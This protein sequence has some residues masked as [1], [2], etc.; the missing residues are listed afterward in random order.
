[1]M[2]KQANYLIIVFAFFWGLIS[3]A[4]NKY[5]SSPPPWAKPYSFDANIHIDQNTVTEGFYYVLF[6]Q[7][8]DI[9]TNS[10]YTHYAIKILNSKSLESL[11]KLQFSFNPSFQKLKIHS[12]KLIR[13]GKSIDKSKDA[14]YIE[15]QNEEEITNSFYIGIKNINVILTDVRIDDIVEFEYTISGANAIFENKFFT[16]FYLNNYF[17]IKHLYYRVI[18]PKNR[19]IYIHINS[20]H[21]NPQRTEIGENEELIWER[22][23]TFGAISEQ[24]LPEWHTALTKVELSEYN[25]WEQVARWGDKLFKFTDIKSDSL[26]RIIVTLEKETTEEKKI[27][28]ALRY[29]QEEIRY[30]GI[31]LGSNSHLPKNLNKII[32]DKF[33]D[34]KDKTFLLCHILN[35]LNIKSYP[36][37]VNTVLKKEIRES[38]PSPAQFNHAVIMVDFKGRHLFFDPTQISQGGDLYTNYFPSYGYGLVLNKNSTDLEPLNVNR[39]SISKIK[40]VFKI[41]SLDGNTDLDVSSTFWGFE[42]NQ[43]RYRFNNTNT[44]EIEKGNKNFYSELYGEVQSLKK[45][46]FSDDKNTNTIYYS[47]KYKIK[48]IWK[49]NKSNSGDWLRVSFNCYQMLEELNQLPV[50]ETPRTNPLWLPF[51]SDRTH[52]IEVYLPEEMSIESN[53]GHSSN[54]YLDFSYDFK[55]HNKKITFTCHTKFKQAFVPAENY[56]AFIESLKPIKEHLIFNVNYNLKVSNKVKDG[57]INWLAITIAI[58]FSIIAISAF[59]FVYF[60]FFSNMPEPLNVPRRFGG[61][62]LVPLLFVVYNLLYYTYT[63]LFSGLLS[64]ATWLSYSDESSLYYSEG[65]PFIVVYS[66]CASLLIIFFSIFS[67]SLFLN[68]NPKTKLVMIIYF[69]S[70]MLLDVID[71]FV[72]LN[73][74]SDLSN[75]YYF[76]TKLVVLGICIIYF[77][78][79]TR[80]KETFVK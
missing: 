46:K 55:Y 18:R 11:S 57:N 16:S 29:V 65:G 50:Q 20:E 47:E 69:S 41:N 68:Y 58:M 25:T 14:N 6:D 80:V 70:L 13:N 36:V 44:L 49:T 3:D 73:F 15:S 19:E 5:L 38:I 79:S 30:F 24:G 26:D 71:Y 23:D 62:V 32:A 78:I 21:D 9:K 4:Q 27:I 72:K 7:Q 28:K 51:P 17:T 66:I 22:Y 60:K 74:Y 37:L 33:G 59:L 12:L 8:I 48:D 64:K 35:K 1:M 42:A 2:Q 40:E 56:A 75:E 53:N 43:T 31:E 76:F 10:Y 67:L 63:V 54:P 34:C 61:L 39:T 77:S 52:I 45:F